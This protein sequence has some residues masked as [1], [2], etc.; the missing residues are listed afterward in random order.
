MYKLMNS[1]VQVYNLRC[2]YTRFE[3]LE[4]SERAGVE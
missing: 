3:E 4:R 1:L 2:M